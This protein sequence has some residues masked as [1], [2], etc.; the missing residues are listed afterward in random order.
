MISADKDVRSEFEIEML[1]MPPISIE[2]IPEIL[3]CEF[4]QT[5]SIL[6][7]PFSVIFS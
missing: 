2:D 7:W 3:L 4:L 1:R 5:N 6:N